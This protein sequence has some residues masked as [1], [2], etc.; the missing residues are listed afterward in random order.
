[1]HLLRHGAG[2][3]DRARGARHEE[4]GADRQEGSATGPGRVGFPHDASVRS[5][6]ATIAVTSAESRVELM[7]DV[8][9]RGVCPWAR[10]VRARAAAPPAPRAARP[11]TRGSARPPG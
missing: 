6:A 1:G 2:P 3:E 4:Q 5:S 7:A 8:I 10:D 9:E 11:R